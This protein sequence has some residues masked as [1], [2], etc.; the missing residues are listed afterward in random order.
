MP[1]GGSGAHENM[2][3]WDPEEDQIII[4]SLERLGPKWSKIVQRLPGRS[5]ASIRN[6]W[7]RIENGRRLRAAGHHPKNRCQRCGLPKRGHVCLAK[8]SNKGESGGL[9]NAPAASVLPTASVVPIDLDRASESTTPL[10]GMGGALAAHT[11]GCG[12][13]DGAL[14]AG[15]D[16]AVKADHEAEAANES[17]KNV[18]ADLQANVTLAMELEQRLARLTGRKDK[19]GRMESALELKQR[20]AKLS[21]TR[22]KKG[23]RGS[24]ATLQECLPL[25]GGFSSSDRLGF[26]VCFSHPRQEHVQA[27]VSHARTNTCARTHTHI[28]P[29]ANL[30]CSLSFCFTGARCGSDS[31]GGSRHGGRHRGRY[32]R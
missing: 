9:G 8:L 11:V 25:P 30:K 15:D 21:G 1:P 27:H 17:A 23:A 28:R 7:Q 20:L 2:R 3:A 22:V 12:Q 14:R 10:E 26:E 6:R 24:H 16:D 4:S 32:L 13:R 31:D 18:S 5:V 19:Q 29:G